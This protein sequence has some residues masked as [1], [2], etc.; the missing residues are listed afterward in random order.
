M[1]REI[2]F[3]AWYG[4]KMWYPETKTPDDSFTTLSFFHDGGIGWGIY[5]S[6][7]DYRV[8]SGEYGQLMQFTGLLDKNEKE[9][10]EGDIIDIS[11]VG[12]AEVVFQAGAFMAR[13]IDDPEA[14]LDCVGFRCKNGHKWTSQIIGNIYENPE[15]INPI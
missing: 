10:Y 2:K 11:E 12:R 14:M 15:L 6:S 3:R 5:D 13:W 1:K 9:I 7:F 4:D 8:V